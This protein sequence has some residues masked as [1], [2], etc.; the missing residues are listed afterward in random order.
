MKNT[1]LILLSLF[2]F[3]SCAG[4]QKVDEQCELAPIPHLEKR[5]DV[6]QLIVEGKPYLALAM[7]LTNSAASSREYMKP[8]WPQLKE[9][10]VNTVLAVVS[11]EMIEPE[12]GK[13]DFKVVDELIED[14][15]ANDLK[16]A[17]LWFGSWKNGYTSYT[18]KWVKKDTGRFPLALTKDGKQLSIMTTLSQTSWEADAR[19]YGELMKHIAQ[20]DREE[21][22]VVMMQVNNEVGLHGYTRDYHPEAVKAFNGP[23]PQALIDYLVKNKEQLL[24]ETRAAWEKQ[25]CKTSGTWEEVFGKG[26][27]T[28]EMFMAWNY[29]HY[30]NAIAQAGK[31]VHPIP[32]FVNAWI[33]QPEDNH[34]G[35]YP[36]G[37]P[38][39]Q[40]HDI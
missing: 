6:T 14:A 13:F 5:G 31:D 23:V 7:E 18:P 39:A 20:V 17:L 22:T 11:W 12:E 4:N 16:L 8:Y 40:N 27:Y 1:A 28:D 26:D 36:A 3:L 29:G 21:Q 30:M 24:P 32:T 10:G 35:N 33:V 37:G 25:G 19:A 38:Q 9:S 15:R 34:P 2:F